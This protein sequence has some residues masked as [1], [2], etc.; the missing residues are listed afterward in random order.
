MATEFKFPDIGEGIIEGEIVKWLVKEGDVIKADQTI[1]QVETDKSVA[2]IPSPVGGTVLKINFKEG[3]TIK[4]GEVLVVIGDSGEKVESKEEKKEEITPKAKEKNPV[5]KAE[6]PNEKIEKIIKQPQ[7]ETMSGLD[8]SEKVL[9]SPAV[10][11]LAR[12]LK[13]DLSKVQGS[14]ENGIVLKKDIESHEPDVHER[15]QKKAAVPQ[16]IVQVKK[17]YD[18]FGY[19]ERV[20]L[21]GIRKTIAINMMKSLEGSAQVTAM[22]D[23]DMSKLWSLRGREKEVWEKRGVKLTFLSFIVKAVIAALKENPILNSTLEGDEILIKKYFNIG[24]A[25]ETD[26]GLMVPVIKI[27]E[28]KT[29]I[30]IA[31]EIVELAKKAAE[32]KL[33]VMDMKGGTFTITNYGS[34]GGTYGTPVLN[35]GEASILGLGRIFDRAVFDEKTGKV[36]N[37]KVLPVSMTFDHRI[38]DGAQAARFLESLKKFLEDPDH[39]LLE[40]K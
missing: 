6:T 25:V 36:K 40:L 31:K 24:V 12:G 37:I 30:Q 14:G 9:A 28:S 5:E 3:D 35:P 27:A 38:L 8:A 39:L 26:V 20:P 18:Q 33:D 1:V 34:I 23:I 11:K 16:Q 29:I 2:D 21:K 7:S 4:V 22:E 17:K 13:I 32:R 10:R 19:L 15:I